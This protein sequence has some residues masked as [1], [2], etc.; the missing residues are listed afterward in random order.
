MGFRFRRSIRL[1]SGLRLNLSKSGISTSIGKPGATVNVGPRGTS[2]TVGLPGTGLSYRTTLGGGN[3]S[4]ASSIADRSNASASPSSGLGCLAV[5][6]L[7]VGAIVL[8]AGAATWGAGLLG[9]GLVLFFLQ[10]QRTKA[11]AERRAT[12]DR[13]R[14]ADLTARFGA[15]ICSRI[16]SREIWLGQTAEQIREA[17]GEPVDVDVKVMKTKSREVWKYDQT[18]VNRFKTRVTVENGVVTGWDQK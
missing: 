5:T 18:G 11:S 4:G 13:Q 8:L 3:V 12:E 2:T 7:L 10:L 14:R 9:T 15:E 16:L 1:G 17:L 6:A